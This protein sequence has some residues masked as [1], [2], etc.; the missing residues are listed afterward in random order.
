[1]NLQTAFLSPPVAMFAYYLKAV[2]PDWSFGTIY[3]GM[4]DFMALQVIALIL[5]MLFPQIALWFPNW[6]FSK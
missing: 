6:L 5:L 2:V 4:M 1:M 3:K